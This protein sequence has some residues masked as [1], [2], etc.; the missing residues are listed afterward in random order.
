MLYFHLLAARENTAAHSCNIQPYCLLTHQIIHTHTHITHTH[1]HAHMH[2][3]THTSHTHTHTPHTTHTHT[4]TYKHTH[5]NTQPFSCLRHQSL[6]LWMSVH[7]QVLLPLILFPLNLEF[8]GFRI[9][10]E[11]HANQ[12]FL[13]PTFYSLICIDNNTQRRKW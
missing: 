7:H 3:H 9:L 6:S 2:A 5:I 10:T 12:N 8:Y 1:T 11:T 4:H 13:I